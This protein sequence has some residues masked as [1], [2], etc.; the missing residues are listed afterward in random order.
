MKRRLDLE[1]PASAVLIKRRAKPVTVPQG[2][3][4]DDPQ[5]A[6]FDAAF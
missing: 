4:R 5:L 2:N 6:L 1:P 3:R